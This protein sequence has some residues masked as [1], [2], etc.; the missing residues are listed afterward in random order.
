MKNG[1]ESELKLH[2]EHIKEAQ[3]TLQAEV[4]AAG[5][6]PDQDKLKNLMDVLGESITKYASNA[7]TIKKRVVP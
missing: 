3:R 6:T 1:F 2:T 7:A 4:D 5:E